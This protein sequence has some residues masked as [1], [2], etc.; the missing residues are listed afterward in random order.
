V[1]RCFDGCDLCLLLGHPFLKESVKLGLLLLLTVQ[2]AALE[3]VQVTTALETNGCDEPLDFRCLSIGLCVLLLGT[4]HLPPNNVLPNII[5]LGQIEELPDLRSPL[6]PQPFRQHI[7]RQPR[8]IRLALLHNHQRQHGNIGPN[9]AT[10]DRLALTLT[11]ATGTVAGVAVGEE[12]FDTGREENALFHGETLLVI[13]ACNPEDVT[14]PFVTQSVA[15]DLLGYF[16]FVEDSVSLLIIN[17]DEFLCPSCGVRDVDLHARGIGVG[18]D[19][20]GDNDV[21]IVLKSLATLWVTNGKVTSSG[22][23]AAMTSKVSP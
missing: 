18:L 3:G 11:S 16:L 22:L 21:E 7:I 20:V 17:V 10:P 19:T 13:A 23:Q 5:L 1:V 6:R 8:N 2:S 12:E 14:F 15:R 4:L 9:D